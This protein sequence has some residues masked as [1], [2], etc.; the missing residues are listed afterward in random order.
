MGGIGVS[1]PQYRFLNNQNPALLV[2]N[3]IT[4]FEAG[5]VGDSRTIKSDS[6]SEKNFGGNLNYLATAFPI[7]P[8]K[9]TASIG[10]M[11]FTSVDYAVAYLDQARDNDGI[12]RDTLIARETGSGGLSQFYFSNGVRLTKELAIGVKAAYIFG[13]I[14]TIYTN[15]T[16]DPEQTIPYLINITE[17]TRVNDFLLSTGVSYSK[18]SLGARNDYTLSFGAT[19]SL[20][21]KF[22]ASKRTEISR[23]NL[24]GGVEESDTLA[25]RKGSLLMPGAL[26]VGLSLSKGYRWT[27]ATEFSY[28][29]WSRFKSIST[30]DEGL[31]ES[32]RAA[33]GGEFTPD[34]FSGENYLK[35]VT[36]RAGVS[37][38]R[39]PYIVNGNPVNDFG[40]NFG[41]S[42]PAGRSS[43]D[44]ALKVGKR[45]NKKENVIEESYLKM[46]FGI[47]FN[48][49]WFVRR[50]FD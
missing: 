14:E 20:E 33:L 15:R 37:Y 46:Y 47:T 23:T 18:D 32:Y 19:Y 9:W 34:I 12:V 16:T 26:T 22:K 4:V 41:F 11:P 43:L 25:L 3:T 36:Y 6:I 48:D 39:M 10:L 30:D 7:K 35:R 49:Q 31:G 2:Y 42:L 5:M 44:L 27:I 8:T 50:K 13:P 1:Q 38:E 28:Q 24:A 29:D 40:I 45:G 21:S 17:K